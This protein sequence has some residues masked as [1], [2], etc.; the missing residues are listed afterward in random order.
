MLNYEKQFMA[1]AFNAALYAVQT[2]SYT[3]HNF[4]KQLLI[5]VSVY[6]FIQKSRRFKALGHR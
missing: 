3:L 4:N 2:I 1:S 6:F 5:T